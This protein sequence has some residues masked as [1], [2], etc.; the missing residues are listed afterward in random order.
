MHKLSDS[1]FIVDVQR[2]PGATGSEYDKMFP[3]FEFPECIFY[4]SPPFYDAFLFQ[5]TSLVVRRGW[6]KNIAWK[7]N[8]IKNQFFC[9]VLKCRW[10][11]FSGK[12][13]SFDEMKLKCH[14]FRGRFN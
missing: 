9:V 6:C 1:L 3:P 2:F 10:K 12:L 14:E 13:K 11:V 4:Y 8:K 7:N 5:I